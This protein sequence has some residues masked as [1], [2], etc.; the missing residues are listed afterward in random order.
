MGAPFSVVQLNNAYLF[1]IVPGSYY[2]VLHLSVS[3]IVQYT[4]MSF[5][6]HQ[7]L[8]CLHLALAPTLTKVIIMF[9]QCPSSD[10]LF[11]STS[12]QHLMTGV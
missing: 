1:Y 3:V 2:G 5:N 6:I 12:L 7:D 11:N 4:T 10:S 9:Q 8:E